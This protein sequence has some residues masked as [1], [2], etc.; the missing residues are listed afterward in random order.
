MCCVVL[1]TSGTAL[2]D[3]SGCIATVRNLDTFRL[4]S[5]DERPFVPTHAVVRENVQLSPRDELLIYETGTTTVTPPY[6]GEPK[7]EFKIVS[8]GKEALAVTLARLQVVKPFGDALR[9]TALAKLCPADGRNVVVIASGSGATGDGQFFVALIGQGGSYRYFCLP[10]SEQG[11]L[12]LSRVEPTEYELWTVVD[13]ERLGNAS[14]KHYEV[15]S[16]RLEAD[17]FHLVSKSRPRKMYK[18][19]TFVNAPIVL[20]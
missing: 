11:K 18:P 9:P 16:F 6:S 8:E 20:R 15:S 17:G 13:S 4:P 1:A 2:S 5:S 14:P 19:E 3:D 10:V 7:A 12:E